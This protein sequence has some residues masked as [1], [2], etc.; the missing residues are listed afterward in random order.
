MS[1]TMWCASAISTTIYTRSRNWAAAIRT[2]K[3]EAR[4]IP[5][6]PWLAWPLEVG[7]RWT[8]Q[9]VWKSRI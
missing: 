9:G 7:K 3:V 4:M 5:P 1:R 2:S 6:H 8:Y